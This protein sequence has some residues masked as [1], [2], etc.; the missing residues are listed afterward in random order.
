MYKNVYSLQYDYMYIVHVVY[1]LKLADC[2]A[3]FHLPCSALKHFM[4]ACLYMYMYISLRLHFRV[5]G[6]QRV[7]PSVRWVLY[8]MYMYR[9]S[10]SVHTCLPVVSSSPAV[11]VLNHASPDDFQPLSLRRHHS[12]LVDLFSGTRASIEG[13]YM[14]CVCILLLVSL[15]V[16][17]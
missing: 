17:P 6:C 2:L 5:Q 1:A 4:C 12:L 10:S 7:F 9:S 13:I 16:R 14:C 11:F 8:Q 15:R 3:C